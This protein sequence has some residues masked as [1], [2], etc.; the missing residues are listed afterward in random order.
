MASILIVE[1]DTSINEL[2]KR[3]LMLTG[4]SCKAIFDGIAALKIIEQ[5][6]FDL[7]ILDI[8]LPGY[9]GF[10]ILKHIKNIPV[11]FVT[12]KDSL[13]D[14]LKGLTSGAEDY[15]VKPFEMLELLARVNIILKRNSKNDE[16]IIGSVKVD[17]NC[18]KVFYKEEE[19]EMTPQE[20]LL[21]EV[22]T[23]NRNIALSREKLLEIAWGFDYEGD[24]RTVDVHIQ[25]LR[26]KLGFEHR[27]K[28]VYKLGYRLEDI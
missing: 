19:I 20:Y 22:L 10:E 2:I 15:L 12:A 23:T 28:T 11:I 9:S 26:K 25:K 7:V 27:I 24:T 18:R 17:F 5:E 14:K 1:D 13:E 16:V 8:M 4:H 3:N 21:L 6:K